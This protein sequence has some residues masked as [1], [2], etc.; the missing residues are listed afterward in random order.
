MLGTFFG[1]DW[2]MIGTLFGRDWDM[3]WAL[4]GHDLGMIRAEHM[5]KTRAWFTKEISMIGQ[6][7]ACPGGSPR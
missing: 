3:T 4:V 6:L 7:A 1:R 5:I 2:D